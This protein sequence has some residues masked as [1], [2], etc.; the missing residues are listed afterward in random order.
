MTRVAVVVLIGLAALA[1][2]GEPWANPRF[3]PNA[4]WLTGA[5]EVCLPADDEAGPVNFN[6]TI[7]PGEPDYSTIGPGSNQLPAPGDDPGALMPFPDWGNDRLVVEL[8]DPPTF[9]KVVADVGPEGEIYLGVLDRDDGI[10]D[11]TLF[12]YRSTDGGQNWSY[13]NYII[14]NAR[15]IKD[16][17]LRVG[18]NGSSVWWYVFVVYAG[19]EGIFV[20]RQRPDLS[21]FHWT[22]IAAGDTF[23]RVV[24]DRNI[25]TPYHLF[26]GWETVSGRLR[27]QSSRDSAQ[28]W[29]NTRVTS[30]D[31]TRPALAAGGDGY[32]YIAYIHR[33]DSTGYVVGRYTNNLISPSMVFNV[34]DTSTNH[35]FR[36]VSVAAARSA[37]G[38]TQSAMVLATRYWVPNGN[39]GVRYGHSV[40]GGQS[41]EPDPWPPTNIPRST[42]RAHSPSVRVNYDSALSSFR[43]VVTMPE[44]TSSFDSIVY[45]WSNNDLINWYGRGVYN[46][47]RATSEFGATVGSSV[48]TGGG[49]IVYRQYASSRIWFDGWY[50][51][52]QA[53]APGSGGPAG[54]LSVPFGRGRLRLSLERSAPVRAVLADAAGRQQAV[55]F[56][57]MLAAGEHSFAVPTPGRG[58]YFVGVDIAGERQRV[59]L[60]ATD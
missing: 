55:L 30:N 49:F 2:G 48:L 60:V 50:S 22:Q 27:M 56:D 35:R 11:D 3:D 21:A 39:T 42:W 40:N 12:L 59:K 32:V 18:A 53:E 23:L 14:G 24:A 8:N 4:V 16:F 54:C 26:V 36:D 58:V 28:T 45:A 25:E 5:Q 7:E 34:C 29:G 47:Y 46:D 20:R 19:D 10:G 44:T 33:S 17:T 51:T 9:G 31:A 43:G 41:W 38:T 37:P 6:V 15:E 1:L 13:L 52:G 57:G